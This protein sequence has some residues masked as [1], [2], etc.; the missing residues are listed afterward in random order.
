LVQALDPSTQQRVKVVGFDLIQ[1][2]LELLAENNIRFLI[3]QNAWHQGYM[4]ILTIVNH[5][6]LRK[7]IP[8]LQYLPLDI[9]VRENVE[10]YLKRTLEIP[11]I[12]V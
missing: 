2:N 12:L 8:L 4:G 7:K 9:I 10:Y 6:I 11:M 1:P 5:L 3:N